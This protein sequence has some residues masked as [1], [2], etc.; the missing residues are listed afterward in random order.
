MDYGKIE[1]KDLGLKKRSY[2]IFLVKLR[3]PNPDPLI[4][5]PDAENC[6]SHLVCG[7]AVPHDEFAVL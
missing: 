7:I 2:C 6:E 1:Y 4:P 5:D 3:H